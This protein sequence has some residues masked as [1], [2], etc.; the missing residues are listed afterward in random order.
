MSQPSLDSTPIEQNGHRKR[1]IAEFPGY[2]I[3]F[4]EKLQSHYSNMTFSEKSWYDRNFQKV[5]HKGW[6]LAMNYINIFQN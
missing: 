5:T 4:I 6:E 1:L 3:N 2:G